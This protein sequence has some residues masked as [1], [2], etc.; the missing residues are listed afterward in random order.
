MYTGKMKLDDV[1]SRHLGIQDQAKFADVFG[2]EVEL[3]GKK[4]VSC[5]QQI[6]SYWRQVSDGSLRKLIAGDEA[7]EYVSR[8]PMNLV[9]TEKAINLLF[10]FLNTPPTQVYESY[11][12][13]IHVHVNYSQESFRTI[14]NAMVLSLI[15]DEL[16]VSQNGE[17]RI[18]NNFCLRAKD[19]LGQVKGLIQSIEQ[20]SEFFDIAVNDR[21]S[22]IN[23]ASTMK[24]GSIEYRSQECHTHEGRLMHW[25]GTLQRIKERA[26]QY[27]DPTEIVQQFS[28]F[29]PT[30]FLVNVLGPYSMKY[31]KVD[32]MAE[33]LRNGMRIAQDLA[34]CSAWN[35]V[36]KAEPLPKQKKL[37][38]K[39]DNF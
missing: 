2:I 1:L 34:F 7:I 29:D 18:A 27:G 8:V 32:G 4:I 31:K 11:R 12:T 36:D 5:G 33:M 14:Y 16:L 37:I 17:H 23:F 9:S 6:L 19:A 24:F 15:L 25:I 13:S 28:M 21:Y 26:R 35:A 39:G 20:G 3:E 38:I 10:T 30:E 22:S